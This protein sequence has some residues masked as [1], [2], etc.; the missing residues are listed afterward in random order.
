MPAML[1]YLQT[2]IIRNAVVTAYYYEINAPTMA[3]LRLWTL[4]RVELPGNHQ[5]WFCATP[6]YPMLTL[7][8]RKLDTMKAKNTLAPFMKSFPHLKPAWK[9]HEV[10][11]PTIAG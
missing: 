3:L 6:V 7:T 1:K 8:V 10:S 11:F 9:L 2:F 5:L 4:S